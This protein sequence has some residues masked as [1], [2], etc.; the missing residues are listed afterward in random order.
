MISGEDKFFKNC[1]FQH[2]KAHC[3]YNGTRM[4]TVSCP[5][6]YLLAQSVNLNYFRLSTSTQASTCRD[7]S[8]PFS[9]PSLQ[10]WPSV[11]L[12][13]VFLAQNFPKHPPM[14]SLHRENHPC[15]KRLHWAVILSYLVECSYHWPR[16]TGH[17]VSDGFKVMLRYALLCGAP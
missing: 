12:G 14:S 4:V 11:Q 2:K 13:E 9:H 6:L 5:T 1:T 15:K 10:S 3:T 16:Q 8:I 7:L 17:F